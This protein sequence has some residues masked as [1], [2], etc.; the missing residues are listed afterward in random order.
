MSPL[1][2]PG[3]VVRAPPAGPGRV[4]ALLRATE[5]KP[6]HPAWKALAYVPGW[7]T[8]LERIVLESRPASPSMHGEGLIAPRPIT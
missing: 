5:N 3:E 1:P 6:I 8:G 4:R 7:S 2:R